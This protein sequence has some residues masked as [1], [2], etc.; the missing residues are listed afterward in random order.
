MLLQWLTTI[1]Q[2]A[3]PLFI[4]GV[5]I[6]A[7]VRRVPVY[8]SFVEGAKEGFT[9]AIRILP[10]LLGMFVAIGIL[11]DSG[12]LGALLAVAAPVIEP[13]GIPS[14]ILPMAILRPLSGSGSL[15]AM[16]ELMSEFGPDSLIGLMAAT[17]QG[18]SETTFYVLTVY[19]G[20]V[21]VRRARHSV[22]VGLLADLAAFLAAV[23]VV[24][25]IF[26]GGG[27]N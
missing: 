23:F 20:A 11:R 26:G 4:L 1:A 16:S 13:F 18:S 15:G 10:F 9:T 19:F 12:A 14:E 5:L 27:A 3:I 8:E 21:G 2:W 25:A 6:A 17:I 24:T 7:A 22:A